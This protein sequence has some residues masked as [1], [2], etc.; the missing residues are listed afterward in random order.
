MDTIRVLD[1][2][3]ARVV[4][5]VEG[6]FWSKR[7]SLEDGEVKTGVV[8]GRGGKG[9][10]CGGHDPAICRFNRHEGQRYFE[11]SHEPQGYKPRCLRNF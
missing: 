1:E 11:I 6:H 10:V 2:D 3:N 7:H 5:H 8:V 4:R 9:E